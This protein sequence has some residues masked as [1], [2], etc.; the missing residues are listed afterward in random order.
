MKDHFLAHC[1]CHVVTRDCPVDCLR[2]VLGTATFHFL[3]RA[4]HAPFPAPV[5]VGQVLE[6]WRTGH[7]GLAAGLGPRRLGEIEAGLVLVGLPLTDARPPAQG[8][9]PEPRSAPACPGEE[10]SS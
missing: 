10:G 8:P 4:E 5:T 1:C 9:P 2:A 7:L 3:A 6:L